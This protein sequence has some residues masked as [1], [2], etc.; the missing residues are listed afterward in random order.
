[1]VKRRQFM[2]GLAALGGSYLLSACGGGGGS[3][4]GTSTAANAATAK[5][6][7]N[8]SAA[9]ASGTTIPPASSITDNTGATWTLSGGVAYKNG[10]DAGNNYKMFLFV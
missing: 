3:D 10:V 6:T 8:S 1:M 4:E 7:A 5:A 2:S 9:S